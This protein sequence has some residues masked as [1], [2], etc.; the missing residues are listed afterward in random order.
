M[1]VTRCLILGLSLGFVSSEW[2]MA[3][4]ATNVWGSVSTVGPGTIS[5]NDRY[6]FRLS[7]SNDG[8]TALYSY[9]NRERRFGI[10]AAVQSSAGWRNADIPDFLR[11]FEGHA[12]LEPQFSPDGQTIVFNSNRGTGARDSY[13]IWYASREGAGWGPAYRFGTAVNSYASEWYPTLVESGRMYVGSERDIGPGGIDIYTL[14]N[15]F[16]GN[17]QAVALPAPVNT[18]FQ[19]YD[20]CID[21]QV[22]FM[23]FIS[24]RPE[25]FGG[26][27]LW[28]AVADSD[29]NWSQVYHV[30]APYNDENNAPGSPMLHPDGQNLIVTG[31]AQAGEVSGNI[32]TISLFDLFAAAGGCSGGRGGDDHGTQECGYGAG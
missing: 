3:Q 26:T 15:P 7:I 32:T 24:D 23:V 8:Q 18:P 10:G 12:V 17:A 21:P 19:D 4:V 30:G 13:D 11:A 14:E 9:Y 20:A 16:A 29:G 2:S 28:I 1:T 5:K 27:D 31:P 25:G 6:E 22:R